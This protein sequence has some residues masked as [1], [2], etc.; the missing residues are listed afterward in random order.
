MITRSSMLTCRGLLFVIDTAPRIATLRP[1]LM[2]PLI[3]SDSQST[4]APCNALFLKAVK[5]QI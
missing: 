4:R 2:S 5:R 1:N 3:E